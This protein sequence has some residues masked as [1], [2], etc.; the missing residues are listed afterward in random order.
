MIVEVRWKI[1]ASICLVIYLLC[2]AACYI[3]VKV[4]FKEFF[5]SENIKKIA[6]FVEQLAPL[7]TA[8]AWDNCG[9]QVFCAD[10][11]IKKV[12]V[13]LSVTNEVIDKAVNE[14]FELIIAHHPV[15]F[16]GLKSITP[17]NLP[18][19]VILKAIKNDISIYAAHTNLDKVDNGIN[20]L[21][22]KKFNLKNVQPLMPEKFQPE[23][24]MGRIGELE[25]PVK[26]CEFLA[27][28]KQILE[29]D[30]IKVVNQANVKEIKTIALCGGAGTSLIEFLPPSV[31]LYLTG[32]VKYHEALEALDFVLVDANHNNTEQIIVDALKSYLQKLNIKVESIKTDNP[33]TIC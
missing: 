14:G 11:D 25:T 32:D 9:W 21:L 19:Q 8:E 24:G 16:K 20:D 15:I 18:G 10:K 28:V 1:Y 30:M 17:V 33:W 23:I 26:L 27:S 22:A 7:K 29:L 12:L 6:N 4:A 13:T 2:I 31:D 5:M 3:I